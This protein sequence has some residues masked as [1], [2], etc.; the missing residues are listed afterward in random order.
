[1]LGSAV[2]V[3]GVVE[4]VP[5]RDAAIGHPL[6][7]RDH[8]LGRVEMIGGDRDAAREL[9][10]GRP[11]L[12]GDDGG[13]QVVGEVRVVLLAWA[14]AAAVSPGRQTTVSLRRLQPA[15]PV[16]PAVASPCSTVLPEMVRLT[17]VAW[18]ISTLRGWLRG[19]AGMVTCRTPLV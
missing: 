7:D 9:G 6:Q 14:V 17:P 13:L 8:D 2:S 18:V 15:P 1:V 19:D 12:L 16:L 3:A 5:E 4:Y 10:D 11:G